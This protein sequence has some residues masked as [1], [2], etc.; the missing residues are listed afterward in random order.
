[1]STQINFPHMSDARAPAMDV[2]MPPQTAGMARFFWLVFKIFILTPGTP[3]TR[4]TS[5]LHHATVAHTHSRT[6]PTHTLTSPPGT[7]T[8]L[9]KQPMWHL[10]SKFPMRTRETDEHTGHSRGPQRPL[11]NT[12]EER[13]RRGLGPSVT[14]K[15][16]SFCAG[17]FSHPRPPLRP[18]PLRPVTLGAALGPGSASKKTIHPLAYRYWTLAS[19]LDGTWEHTYT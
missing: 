6:P 16:Q 15:S 18:P 3:L 12:H 9:T 5:H 4:A 11:Q 13:R 8:R 17:L 10:H 1:M 7:R 19:K 2:Q 14:A